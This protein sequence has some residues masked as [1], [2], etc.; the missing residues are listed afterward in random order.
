MKAQ[1]LFFEPHE[2]HNKDIL[3]NKEKW[4]EVA[5]RCG[6]VFSIGGILI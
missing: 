3:H 4:N 5:N 1:N 2:P 6:W